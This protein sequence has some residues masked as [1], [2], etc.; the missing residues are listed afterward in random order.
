MVRFVIRRLGPHI[1]PM[2][3]FLLVSLIFTYPGITKFTTHAIGDRFDT[4]QNIWNIWWMKKALL[5]LH[6]NPYFT[7][8]LFHPHGI[9]LV[10][11]TMNPFNG[12]IALPLH[13][14]FNLITVY[15][16][17]LVASFVLTGYF[18]Y[19]LAYYLTKHRTASVLAGLIFTLCPYHTA[20]ALA[21]LQL[22]S[23]Q[24]IPLYI[25]YLFKSFDTPRKR[26]PRL[27]ALFL[28]LTALC[29]W[30][31]LFFLA[32]FTGLYALYRWIRRQNSIRFIVKTSV[33]IVALTLI[34]LS[35]IFI[36]MIRS[37]V[38]HDFIGAHPPRGLSADLS[39]FFI[40]GQVQ[41]LG[42]F[43]T[44]ITATYGPLREEYGNYIGYTVLILAILGFIKMRRT[45]LRVAFLA[46]SAVIFFVLSL[47]WNLHFFGHSL[48]SVSL[49][50]QWL[51]RFCFFFQF[52]GV[53]ERFSAMMM[54]CMSLLATFGLV[55]ISKHIHGRK[56][57]LLAALIFLLLLMEYITIPFTVSRLPHST[58]YDEMADDGYDY[59]IVDIP[60]CA[61]SLYAQIFHGKRLMAG[62]VTRRTVAA[63]NFL[64]KTPII[65]NLY[66]QSPTANGFDTLPADEVRNLAAE[67]CRRYNIGYVIAPYLADTVLFQ[68]LGFVEVYKDKHIRAFR[69]AEVTLEEISIRKK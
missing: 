41:T 27:A 60:S 15:N 25:L 23:M 46:V 49:P 40:P 13:S 6:Q 24:F 45:D 3:F 53:P 31:Y 47:G 7:D 44:T 5:E 12:I 57:G 48:D 34:A 66:S 50:Y 22:V 33:P 35:P 43:F 68:G 18:M 32:I 9:T 58:F 21:H 14:V 38:T 56:F 62:Y 10:F 1:G 19:L 55:W 64:E 16:I 11:Q 29:S 28:V 4:F 61:N 17:I 51:H 20:H 65:N 26:Y 2:A 59:A 36:G 30:Y 8:Y 39:S 67:A 52:T 42:R 54:F 69:H 63:V 37:V